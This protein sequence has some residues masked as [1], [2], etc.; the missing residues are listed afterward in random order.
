MVPQHRFADE[1]LTDVVRELPDLPALVDLWRSERRP[2]LGQAL[3]DDGVLRLEELAGR[4]REHA[5]VAVVDLEQVAP[6]PASRDLIPA[7]YCRENQVVPLREEDGHL[8]V[9]MADPLAAEVLEELEWLSGRPIRARYALPVAM[10]RFFSGDLSVVAETNGLL[11]ELDGAA[12]VATEEELP[13]VAGPEGGSPP[14]VRLVY[15]LLADAVGRGASEIRVEHGEVATTV[16]FRIDGVLREVLTLPR[17][18][19]AGPLLSRLKMLAGLDI[20]VRGRPQDG[21]VRL[22]V[23]GRAVELRVSVVPTPVGEAATVHV[24]DERTARASLSGLGMWPGSVQTF[25]RWL[26]GRGGLVLVAGPV[27]AGTRT[28]LYA[29][30]RERVGAGETVVAIEDALERRVPWLEQVRVDEGRGLRFS[31]ALRSVLRRYPDTVMVAGIHDAETA[32]LAVEA[33]GSGHRVVAALRAGTAVAAVERLVELSGD[34]PSVASALRGILAQRLVRRRCTECGDR[35]PSEAG[36]S[37]SPEGCAACGFTGFRGRIP[38]VET[39]DPVPEVVRAVAGRA[40][41]EEVE[42]VAR[43]EGAFRSLVDDGCWHLSMGRTTGDELARSL[44]GTHGE[45]AS[46]PGEAGPVLVLG[47]RADLGEVGGPGAVRY[48]WT[49]DLPTLYR[50]ALEPD[51]RA[52][53]LD[54][55]REDAAAGEPVETLRRVLGLRTLPVLS[56]LPAG[57]SSRRERGRGATDVLR[58]PFAPEAVGVRLRALL[59]RSQVW[60]SPDEVARPRRPVDEERRLAVLREAGI[61]DTEPE[62]AFDEITRTARRLLDVPLAFVSLVDAEREWFKS[63]SGTDQEEGPRDLSFCGHGI[64]QDHFVIPDAALDPRFA[65]NP[66]VVGP[67]HVRFYAGCP[68]RSPDGHALGMLCVK[69]HEPR[70]LSAGELEILEELAGRAA[71]EIEL[72]RSAG[73]PLPTPPAGPSC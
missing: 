1:W 70:S 30:L 36:A 24:L 21:R 8:E 51:V 25:R 7:S 62:E 20:L 2:H 57:R 16:R 11:A 72:R 69:D 14:V 56:V 5:S 67:P 71:R 65:D 28:T 61:L 43:A 63:R 47:T 49:T 10:E 4:L 66:M 45:D 48:R 68:I 29:A 55:R 52:V 31:T 15:G 22:K 54:L 23:G 73:A 19:G 53:V 32:R 18:V 26:G 44:E 42:R 35:S 13:E 38:L 37:A 60:P 58:A 46:D 17:F 6:D 40:D 59:G 50:W 39:L 9:A 3:V 33:A 64:L 34:A 12:T 41:G 27:E